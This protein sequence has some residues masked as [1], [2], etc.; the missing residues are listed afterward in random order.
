[1][2]SLFRLFVY[3]LAIQ[4]TA[5][6][7]T[8]KDGPVVSADWLW[9]H[10]N[11]K[12]LVILHS[13]WTRANY[14]TEHIPGARFLWLSGFTEGTMDLS[15]EL[16]D[17]EK[18]QSM[19]R[20]LGISGNSTIVVYFEGQNVTMTARMIMTLTYYGLSDVNFLDGGLDAWKRAGH[21]VEK[22]IPS[23]TKSTYTVHVTPGVVTNAEWV[24]AHLSDPT[25]TVID[26]RSTRFYEG[27]GGGLPRP[28]HIP[29]AVNIPYSS[30]ADSTN[31]LFPAD[32]LKAMFLKAG[33]K[34][35]S[36]VV[37]YCH[38]GQQASLLYFVSRYLGYDAQLYDGSFEDWSSREDLPVDNPSDK[39]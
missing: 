28:G 3:S 19:L 24:K 39:K 20:D 27:N 17:P 22:G 32:T 12:N 4:L 33:V 5:L 30:V 10:R 13:G 6:A 35:G 18:A 37:T 8:G 26:A 31:M 21:P 11:D 7:G 15:T 29:G 23:I 1:M 9:K 14:K 38:V 25:V 36:K 34:P 16:P 2:K